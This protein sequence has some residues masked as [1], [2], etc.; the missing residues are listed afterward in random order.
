MLLQWVLGA[1]GARV[2]VVVETTARAVEQST[3]G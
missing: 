2:V 3:T 1:V